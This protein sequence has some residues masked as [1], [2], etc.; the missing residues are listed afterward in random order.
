MEIRLAG[1]RLRIHLLL[2]PV[3]GVLWYLSGFEKFFAFTAALVLHELFHL[4]MASALGVRVVSMELLPFGCAV[5]MGGMEYTAKGKEVLIAAAGPAASLLAAASCRTL[6]PQS[7]GFPEDFFRSNLALGAM[8][9]MP[10]LPLDGGR[11][12]A[13]LLEIFLPRRTAR[14]AAGIMGVITGLGICICGYTVKGAGSLSFFVMGGFMVFSSLRQMRAA[15]LN[16]VALSAAKI[17]GFSKTALMD[18]KNTACSGESTLGEVFVTLD[19]RKYN[20]VYVVDRE[21]RI[22]EV[23]DEGKLVERILREGNSAKLLNK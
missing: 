6:F 2:F 18:V 3:C 11:I 23:L 4:F 22:R 9:L 1:G 10:A 7:M 17:R 5:N 20:L 14:A 19:Q 13:V 12:A 21:M 16:A 15:E 8:N